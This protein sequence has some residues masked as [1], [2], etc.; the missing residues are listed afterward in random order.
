MKSLKVQAEMSSETVEDLYGIGQCKRKLR[1][2]KITVYVF[3]TIVTEKITCIYITRLNVQK[4]CM[5]PH[6]NILISY[7]IRREVDG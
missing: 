4:T 1:C 6:N 2:K 7:T 3:S 5:C